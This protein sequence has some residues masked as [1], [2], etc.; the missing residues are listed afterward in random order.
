[1]KELSVDLADRGQPWSA[2]VDVES[3]L[4]QP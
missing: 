2:A 4:R 1:V 3:S